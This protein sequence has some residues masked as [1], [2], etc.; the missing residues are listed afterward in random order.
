M[1]TFLIGYSFKDSD[2]K[3]LKEKLGVDRTQVLVV[4]TTTFAVDFICEDVMYWYMNLH[5]STQ[6]KLCR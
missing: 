4:A 3:T 6:S 5:L 1:Q 2:L